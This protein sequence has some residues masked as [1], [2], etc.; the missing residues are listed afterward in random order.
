MSD[1]PEVAPNSDANATRRF[2]GPVDEGEE[3]GVRVGVGDGVAVGVS[4][5]DSVAVGVGVV[6]SVGGAVLDAYELAKGGALAL[7]ESVG[8]AGDAVL[9][10][11]APALAEGGTVRD[12]P[13]GKGEA[14]SGAAAVLTADMDAL[15]K[16][17]EEED[18]L[19]RPLSRA[20]RETEGLLLSLRRELSAEVRVG[21]S[22]VAVGK[23]VADGEENEL[24]EGLPLFPGDPLAL[25]LPLAETQV[26]ATP[27]VLTVNEPRGLALRLSVAV[28]ESVR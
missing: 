5:G 12:T 14:V 19:P 24:R 16:A 4:V 26:L 27:I 6:L 8:A 2:A 25:A 1:P 3:V 22:K 20:E 7:A 13:V 10:G 28:G 23:R 17:L 15:G 18:T 9:G 21:S 11:V